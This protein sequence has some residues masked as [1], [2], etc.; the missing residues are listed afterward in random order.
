MRQPPGPDAGPP[1]AGL[2]PDESAQ[3]VFEGYYEHTNGQQPQLRG[4]LTDA[5]G[6]IWYAR[7]R[8]TSRRQ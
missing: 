5:L 2:S 8:F 1:P 7:F 4:K 6:V 3:L